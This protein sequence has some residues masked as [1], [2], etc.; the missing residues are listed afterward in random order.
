MALF[1]AYSMVVEHA[2]KIAA[3]ES[4]VAG[5]RIRV[6]VLTASVKGKN[7][8]IKKLEARLVDSATPDELVD[9]LNEYF[10]HEDE[11]SIPEPAVPSVGAAGEA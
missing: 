8:R 1:G 2:K 4:E 9:M 11:D 5:L 3:F 10:M 7:E 6:R